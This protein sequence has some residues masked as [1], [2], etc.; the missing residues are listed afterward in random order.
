MTLKTRVI[1]VKNKDVES[2]IAEG[3][4]ILQANRNEVEIEILDSGSRGFLGVGARQARVK[5]ALKG[6]EGREA[7]AGPMGEEPHEETERDILDP[8]GSRDA[9]ES[10]QAREIIA[11]EGNKII[12]KQ[13]YRD[14]YPVIKGDRE[15]RLYADGEL[16][17]GSM[18]LTEKSN[19][20]YEAEDSEARNEIIITVSDD[21]L[22]AYLEI[23]RINGQVV[24]AVIL[25]GAGDD[26]DFIISTRVVREIPPPELSLKDIYEEMEK[27]NIR[28]G[29]KEEAVREAL[30]NP[31]RKYLIAEG[32]PLEEGSD[33]WIEFLYTDKELKDE[34]EDPDKNVDYFSRNDVL[35]VKRGEIVA[36]KHPR[37]EG[38]SGYTVHG[39]VM[40][41]PE[42]KDIEWRV[43]KGIQIVDDKAVAI[44]SGRPVFEGG[45]LDISETLIINRDVDINTGNISFNG[46]VLVMGNVHDNF[47]VEASGMIKVSGNVTQAILRAEGDIIVRGRIINSRVIAG[48]L[49]TFY[50]EAHRYLMSLA[51][52]FN[53]METAI[54]QLKNKKAFKTDDLVKYG[55]KQL[56]QLLLDT[57]FN[58]VVNLI[59]AFYALFEDEE[60]NKEYILDDLRD[61]KD[62]LQEKIKESS[63][64]ALVKVSELGE[65][66]AVMTGVC[67]LL[68]KI[69]DSTS[70]I[71]TSYIQKSYI[72]ASGNVVTANEG[73][74]NSE[75]Y[76]GKKVIFKGEP[77]L[78]RGGKI[79]AN[80]DVII[81]ELGSPGGSS[82]EV[83]VPE[84]GRIKANQVY[85]NV[86]IKIGE[87]RYK[88]A[89][90]YGRIN[91][92]LDEDGQIRLH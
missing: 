29:I 59:R 61:L 40:N 9:K 38:K 60:I 81:N 84:N 36:V 11:V 62:N 80:D 65:L 10:S 22:K 85:A 32:K 67:E 50:R 13:L 56:I 78:C 39:E 2:A 76:A 26:I 86:L 44:K 87:R 27:E 91:A 70:N 20:S 72:R 73:A 7:E 83:E 23:R 18:V 57:K 16:L 48:G 74:Y 45:K 68:D 24:D 49:A 25:P 17:E 37:R 46:D 41:P 30:E 54:I 28:R 79:V 71:W 82:L 55:E 66:S 33:A 92:R 14:R 88:F 6:A 19:I 34:L 75:I 64:C 89:D 31:G 35:S 21:R 43:G 3:L 77:G 1:L 15:I 47:K 12:L 58:N 53:M 42:Y 51:N 8:D 5:L 69:S 63:L 52:L 90:N 4:R